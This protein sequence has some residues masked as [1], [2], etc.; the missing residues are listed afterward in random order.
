MS[1]SVM[2]VRLAAFK[3]LQGRTFAENRVFDSRVDALN[4]TAEDDRAPLIVVSVD[5]DRGTVEGRDLA[6]ASREVELVIEIAIAARMRRTIGAGETEETVEVPETDAGLEASVGLVGYQVMRALQADPGAW[7]EVFRALVPR[8]FSFTA[9]RG[10]D[11]KNGVRYAAR[12][13]VLRCDCLADPAFGEALDPDLPWGRF[14][15]LAKAD[16]SL[17]RLGKLIEAEIAGGLLPHW[18]AAQASLGLTAGEAS[19]IGIAPFLGHAESGEA[20]GTLDEIILDPFGLMIDEDTEEPVP[21]PADDED[22]E[23]DE[24]EPDPGAP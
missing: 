21:A 22:D 6:A 16:A 3:A 13:I 24:D 18:Q 19:G 8:I 10:A 20:L 17:G 1:L 15:A 9:R 5:E 14:V 2:A 12:Q 23:D 7:S 11:V 4:F